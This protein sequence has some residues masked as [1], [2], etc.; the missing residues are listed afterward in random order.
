MK[1]T[2]K[3]GLLLLVSVAFIGCAHMRGG[4]SWGKF[5]ADKATTVAMQAGKMDKNL[6]YYYAGPDTDPT[7]IMGLNKKYALANPQWKPIASTGMCLEL[8]QCMKTT[9]AKDRTQDL[10]GFIMYAPDGTPIGTWF[11]DLTARMRVR[12]GD[13]NKVVVYTPDQIPESSGD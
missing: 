4:S 13:G 11:S 5:V 7:A 6:N 1:M 9:D 3:L 12:M 8:V 10:Y 2:L